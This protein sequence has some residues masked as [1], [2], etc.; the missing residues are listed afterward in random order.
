MNIYV[1]KP[2]INKTIFQPRLYIIYSQCNIFLLRPEPILFIWG[3][4]TLLAATWTD[5]RHRIFGI[6]F[7]RWGMLPICPLLAIQLHIS[8]TSTLLHTCSQATQ[9]FYIARPIFK[10]AFVPNMLRWIAS[11][12]PITILR[13]NVNGILDKCANSTVL[14]F[15]NSQRTVV[16]SANLAVKGLKSR[17]SSLLCH[18]S[19]A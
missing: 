11:L 14:Q 18:C 13:W 17:L 4:G 8:T 1:Y 6:R 19:L 2:I 5:F 12:A 9:T 15:W 3:Y 7:S 16:F 10:K